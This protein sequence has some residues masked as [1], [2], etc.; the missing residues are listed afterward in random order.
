MG[1]FW[2]KGGRFERDV[3]GS[4]PAPGDELVFELAARADATRPARR[5]SSLVFAAAVLVLTVGLLAS[6]ASAGYAASGTSLGKATSAGDQYKPVVVVKSAVAKQTKP[7]STKIAPVKASG[8][9]PFT[10]ISLAGTAV[11]GLG[12]AGLG[13][14]LRRRERRDES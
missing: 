7:A 11:L 9:L 1:G 8:G 13:V 2:G 4:R 12:L 10:G 14:R 5:W 6:L 3:L